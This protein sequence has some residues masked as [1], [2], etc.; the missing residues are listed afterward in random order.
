MRAPHRIVIA[1]TVLIV[2]KTVAFAG[3]TVLPS[4]TS[5]E[6]ES[7]TNTVA[8]TNAAMFTVECV[9][10]KRVSFEAFLSSV[11]NITLEWDTQPPTSKTAII[12][13]A[14][15]IKAFASEAMRLKRKDPC[16]CEHLCSVLFSAPKKDILVSICDHCFV[17]LLTDSKGKRTENHEYQMPGEFYKLFQK[18]RGN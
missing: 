3:D 15:T 14:A 12:T 1:I 2:S 10:G 17:V 11:T 9:D 5:K 16:E 13:D 7:A 8:A 4:G 18:H 6:L